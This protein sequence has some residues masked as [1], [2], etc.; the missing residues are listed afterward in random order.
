ME[1]FFLKN[2]NMLT[3]IAIKI[4]RFNIMKLAK[5]KDKIVDR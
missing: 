3:T 4:E 5:K 1:T 2:I